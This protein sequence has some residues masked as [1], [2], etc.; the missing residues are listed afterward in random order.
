MTCSA[1]DL[2]L[3]S[4][5]CRMPRVL[6]SGIQVSWGTLKAPER[7]QSTATTSCQLSWV[8]GVMILNDNL[9]LFIDFNFLY[10]SFCPKLT[11]SDANV[12]IL[13]RRSWC[14]GSMKLPSGIF[15]VY[16]QISPRF[17]LFTYMRGV[18]ELEE[19]FSSW[20]MVGFLL[21]GCWISLWCSSFWH[22]SEQWA[23]LQ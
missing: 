7:F 3:S 5:L 11:S 20:F 23:V 9:L 14:D 2:R 17:S 15:Q 13:V 4:R 8:R 19:M 6:W 1:Q 10:M 21:T 12:Y 16:L 18:R 22:P